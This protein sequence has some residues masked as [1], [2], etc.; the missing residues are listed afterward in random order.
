MRTERGAPIVRTATDCMFV[1]G[2]CLGYLE[3]QLNVATSALPSPLCFA[4]HQRSEPLAEGQMEGKQK[5]TH[6]HTLLHFYLCE[7]SHC[8]PQ[9]F[10]LTLTITTNSLTL[11]PV[12]TSTLKPCLH[13]QMVLWRCEGQPKWPH[14]PN[15]KYI[16]THVYTRIYN[17][18]YRCI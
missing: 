2:V 4:S 9:L 11:D 17:D 7:D 3:W 15:I 1:V 13:P 12:E 10:N 8:F 6:T 16:H 18:I 14:I 5:A